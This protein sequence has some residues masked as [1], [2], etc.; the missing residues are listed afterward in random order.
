M[1]HE[2]DNQKHIAGGDDGGGP[3]RRNGFRAPVASSFHGHCL[4]QFLHQESAL[5][6]RF[7]H[8]LHFFRRKDRYVPVG[9][10]QAGK[11]AGPYSFLGL[12]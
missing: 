11:I 9:G 4:Q 6:Q 7:L 12:V 8:V 5:Q 1:N 3:V 2:Q 10:S